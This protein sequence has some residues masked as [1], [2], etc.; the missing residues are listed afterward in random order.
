MTNEIKLLL[1]K[2]SEIG[3]KFFFKHL[4]FDVSETEVESVYKRPKSTFKFS[5]F[6]ILIFQR[7]RENIFFL[8]MIF[9][10]SAEIPRS[11]DQIP[12]V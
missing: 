10:F 1:F 7:L 12:W 3:S 9:L 6:F 4:T 5:I 8:P 11:Y 2:T